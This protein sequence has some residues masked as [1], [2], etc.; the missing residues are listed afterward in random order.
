MGKKVAKFVIQLEKFC[1]GLSKKLPNTDGNDV[2]IWWEIDDKFEGKLTIIFL[3][4]GTCRTVKKKCAKCQKIVRRQQK[5]HKI[6]DRLID[7]SRIKSFV[8]KILR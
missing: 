6:D 5:I 3:K 1:Q 4:I 8:R 7:T 2:K